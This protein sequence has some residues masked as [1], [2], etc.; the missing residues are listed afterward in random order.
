MSDTVPIQRK[1]HRQTTQE[2]A[3]AITERQHRVGFVGEGQIVSLVMA[4]QRYLKALED[5]IREL[6][7]EEVGRG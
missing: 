1:D 6:R 4:Q 2:L 3:D 7:H 5:Q